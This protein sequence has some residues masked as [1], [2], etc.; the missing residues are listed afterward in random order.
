MGIMGQTL[1]LIELLVTTCLMVA[2]AAIGSA[3]SKRPWLRWVITVVGL[4]VPLGCWA[5]ITYL[6]AWLHMLLRVDLV[7]RPWFLGGAAYTGAFIIVAGIILR[8]GLQ[9][10]RA[11]L[12]PAWKLSIVFAAACMLS[13]MTFW[14]LDLNAKNQLGR[15]RA[16]AGSI[17]AATFPPKIPDSQNAARVYEQAFESLGMMTNIKP[18]DWA[19]LMDNWLDSQEGE[20]STTRPSDA[21]IREILK[22]NARGLNQLRRAA[23]MK[24][25]NFVGYWDWTDLVSALAPQ[26]SN[27]RSAAEL[28]AADA[29]IRAIDGDFA[30]AVAD[31]NAS[32][33]MSEHLT[34]E[35]TVLSALVAIAIESRVVETMEIVLAGGNAT[36]SELLS[37]R[38]DPLFSHGRMVRSALRGEE[39]MVLSMFASM[40]DS[41]YQGTPNPSLLPLRR[42]FLIEDEIRGYNAA[43]REWQRLA[44]MP[45]HLGRDQWKSFHKRMLEQQGGF[46]TMMLPAISAYV[47]RAAESDARRRLASLAVA[48]TIYRIKTGGLPESLDTLAPE[49]IE[50]IPT[51]PFNGEPMRMVRSSNGGAVLY[52]VGPD[53]KDDGGQPLDKKK[54]RT[55]DVIFR[56]APKK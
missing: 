11:A 46:V 44:V 27:M 39:A 19:I 17:I 4:L 5:T 45:F 49:F 1:L 9:N 28:L 43:V 37:L 24:Q 13:L 52:S 22:T 16:R 23:G 3:R 47:D 14:N 21:K 32:F 8:R 7:A 48:M 33:G 55:G 26:M 35:P 41:G 40:G 18:A 53:L 10:R 38:I 56:L 15:L 31:L 20:Q 36:A 6:A 30:G 29:R 51:D 34:Q 42:V 50:T 54:G 2:V 12:W 25:C